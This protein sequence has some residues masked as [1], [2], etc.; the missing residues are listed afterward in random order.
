MGWD[1]QTQIVNRRGW[2]QSAGML[3]DMGD[4]KVK[5][6]EQGQLLLSEISLYN[7]AAPEVIKIVDTPAPDDSTELLP[8][9][10]SLTVDKIVSAI[11]NSAND[12]SHPDR[13]ELAVRD[14]FAFLGFQAERLGGSGK[15]DVLLDAALGR[16]DSYRV[17]VDCKTSAS[18]SVGDHQVDWVTL[19][20]HKVK[21][22]ANHILLVAPN[23]SGSRLFTRA[24]Q[25]GVTVM[26]ADQ[27]VGLCRQ[28][29]KTPLGLDD[30]RSLS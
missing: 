19:A 11:K 8:P 18:G 20:E 22:D 15:T 30:Y 29:G 26:S 23:P 12:S 21:H 5:L 10:T 17:V 24:S 14:T 4:G 9:P 25:Y 13:F 28:H 6:S 7:P 2:L 27:L 1:T 16:S 3:T